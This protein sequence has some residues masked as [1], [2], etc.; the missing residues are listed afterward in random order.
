MTWASSGSTT[1]FIKR[2]AFATPI[3]FTFHQV[4]CQLQAR[5]CRACRSQA[6]ELTLSALAD[7]LGASRTVRLHGSQGVRNLDAANI[8]RSRVST[9]RAIL[10]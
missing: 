3:V 5:L 8:E 10:P 6:S 7:A 4:R 9:A 2:V 1:L